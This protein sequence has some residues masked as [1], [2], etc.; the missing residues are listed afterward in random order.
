VLGQKVTSYRIVSAKVALSKSVS[1]V[2][3]VPGD[4]IRSKVVASSVASMSRV[5]TTITSLRA[6]V[7]KISAGTKRS[8]T[9]PSPVPKKKQMRLDVGPIYPMLSRESWW[10]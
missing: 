7:L 3:V 4:R 6:V 10:D 8:G 2:K 1:G 9:T 5:R